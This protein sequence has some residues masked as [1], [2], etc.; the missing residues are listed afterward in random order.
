MFGLGACGGGTNPAVTEDFAAER[1]VV[2]S[3]VW[4]LSETGPH[5][6][7]LLSLLWAC[8]P[9]GEAGLTYWVAWHRVL[10]AVAHRDTVEVMVEVLSVA[11]QQESSEGPYTSR[12]SPRIQTDTLS[13][14]VIREAGRP[15]VCGFSDQGIDLGSYGLPENTSYAEGAS[16]ALLLRQADSIRTSKQAIPGR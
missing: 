7:T 16:R 4:A 3:F 10:A 8:K 9:D 11:E 13:W 1:A 12:V 2:D 6:P 15:R 5:D 14:R